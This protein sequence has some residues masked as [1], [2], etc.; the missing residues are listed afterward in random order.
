M[1]RM[2]LDQELVET[3]V[4]VLLIDGDRSDLESVG[5]CRLSRDQFTADG[6]RD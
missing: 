5:G 6:Y 4:V 2:R 1:F 3:N